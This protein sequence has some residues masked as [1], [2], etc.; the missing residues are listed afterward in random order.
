VQVQVAVRER[1]G[2]ARVRARARA[3]ADM[4]T[5]QLSWAGLCN[6]CSKQYS[7]SPVP[8]PPLLCGPVGLGWVGLG[9]RA[10]RLG[11]AV[12]TYVRMFVHTNIHTVHIASPGLVAASMSDPLCASAPTSP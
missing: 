11:C 6:E 10:V 4:Y 8:L 2:R 9:S 7:T 5:T 1:Q 12:R 3:R